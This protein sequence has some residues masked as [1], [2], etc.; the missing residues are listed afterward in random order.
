MNKERNNITRAFVVPLLLF[1]RL[2][3]A[4]RKKEEEKLEMM[5]ESVTVSRSFPALESR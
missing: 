3:S 4:T 2:S 5:S 1:V